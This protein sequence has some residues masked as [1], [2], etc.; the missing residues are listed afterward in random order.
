[1]LHSWL[2]LLSHP[3]RAVL[4]VPEDEK[5]HEDQA[6]MNAGGSSL[7]SLNFK[8]DILRCQ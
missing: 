1:M 5:R 6:A 8:W 7:I 2:I 3:K 4:N